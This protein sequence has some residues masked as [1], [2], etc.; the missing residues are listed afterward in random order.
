MVNSNQLIKLEETEFRLMR[1]LINNYCGIFF[2]DNSAYLLEK[3]LQL[4]LQEH[5]F[6]SFREYY[7][8]LIYDKNKDVELTNIV[9]IL[10][11]NET[12]FF[13]EPNQLRAFIDEVLPEIKERKNSKNIK[14]LRVWSAGCSSGEEPYSLAMLILESGHFWDWQ[15][16]IFASDISNRVL[17]TAR[18]GVYAK[19]SFRMTEQKYID[20]YFENLD[21]GRY[22]VVDRVKKLVNFGHLNLF[23]STMLCLIGKFDVIICRNVIIYFDLEAKKKVISSFYDRLDNGGFLLLGHAESL[24]GVSAAFILK[25]LRNDMVYQKALSE[26]TY[27]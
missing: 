4:R 17:H 7:Y 10:T 23:D 18:K 2:E 26:F 14:K 24:M 22:K 15:V 25:H 16:E 21:H 27:F 12:Y 5:H 3:R 6:R 20:K 8:Y 13:R 19:A 9:D 11:T 1:D